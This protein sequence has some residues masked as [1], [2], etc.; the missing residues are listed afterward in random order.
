MSICRWNESSYRF[1]A[2]ESE[3]IT[4]R[5][6]FVAS[7]DEFDACGYPF[8]TSSDPF[9]TSLF[10]LGFARGRFV[11]TGY[12]FVVVFFRWV[13]RGVR[14]F[15]SGERRFEARGVADFAGDASDGP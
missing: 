7:S 14:S 9:E 1:V 8:E 5:C 13:A 6:P 4:S 10:E 12:Q 15:A 11:A 2:N 3:S